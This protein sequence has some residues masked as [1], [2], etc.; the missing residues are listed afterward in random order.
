MN[1]F[2]KLCNDFRTPPQ[3]MRSRPL[4]FWNAP[5]DKITFD[6]IYEIM[7]RSKTMS[8]YQGFG[9]L[10]KWVDGYMSEHYLELYGFALKCAKD[11]GMKMCLY[12]ENGFP[13][14]SAGGLLNK[15]Y[16]EHTVKRLDKTELSVKGPCI[17]NMPIPI[18]E[19]RIYLGTVAVN[20]N[21]KSVI[22]VSD[23]NRINTPDNSGGD[24]VTVPVPQGEWLLMSF[25]TVKDGYDRVD[26]LDFDAV[27]S[28]IHITHE[29]YYQ[30]FSE[31]FGNVID[32][33]F[34]DEPPLYQACSR[35]WTGKFNIEFEKKYGFNPI[36]YY[37]ALWGDIGEKTD[38]ARNLLLSFR[39][40]LFAVKYIKQMN[41][42]CNSK[43][44]KLTGHMDQEEVINPVSTCGDLMKVFKYQDIPGID[45][46]FQY[47]R[48]RK[49]YKVVSSSAYNYDKQLV[50]TET[51]G[52][53]GENI[54]IKNLYRDIINQYA[55]G[56]NLIVPHAVWYDTGDVTFPPELSYRS[57]QY[58]EYLKEYN[59][60]TARCSYLLQQGIHVA[61]IALL[62]PIDNLYAS[63]LF[64]S[65]NP[66]LGSV[67]PEEADYLDVGDL[68]T[69]VIHQDF[70][71]LHP[72]VLDEKCTVKDKLLV[73]NNEVNRE[74]YKVAIIPGCRVISFRALKKIK[75][76]HDNGGIVIATSYLPE[77]SS[78]PE[79]DEDVKSMISHIF[80]SG[81]ANSFFLG[82]DYEKLLPEILS[83]LKYRKDVF[84]EGD[85]APA[86]DG[87]LAYI[88][89]RTE[90][91][92]I[93]FIGNSEE[94]EINCTMCIS[95]GT[96]YCF[97]PRTGNIQTAVYEQDDY[98]RIKISV[99]PASSLFIVV[100]RK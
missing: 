98:T 49:A 50:M 66:Y 23:K 68:L 40:E 32:S 58:G 62:Y 19:Y 42:W 85:T 74:I 31:F 65:G 45:E 46:I 47:D 90:D 34:Y 44:I 70:T 35:T 94:R 17:T 72:E 12:D 27:S 6:E 48:A 91:A 3:D 87:Y 79:H 22:D 88:H 64:D 52:A 63:F 29:V 25:A 54:G 9:I 97:D 59:D 100:E 37:P 14:G 57:S 67:V 1:Y 73:L 13:S 56:I 99:P 7:T 53:M 26:Y 77:K 76:F 96:P 16:P 78:E 83:G 82:K 61:D 69:T 84:F 4:W 21:D 86:G 55:K 28:F 10:P 33:A 89:K 30:R 93:Y 71:Y 8:G 75:E 5:L 24:T 41:D 36:T 51:Y 18:G 15:T 81:S 11:L 43:G 39:T 2:D 20:A 92:D 38:F 95:S 80:D 60:F